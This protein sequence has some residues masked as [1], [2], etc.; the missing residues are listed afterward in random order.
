VTDARG[1]R[2]AVGS[3][4]PGL[5]VQAVA[6]LPAQIDRPMATK[7]ETT[8]MVTTLPVVQ[9]SNAMLQVAP[10][11]AP[12]PMSM[13]GPGGLGPAT[14]V[15]IEQVF[16]LLE[17]ASGC[18]AKNRYRVH[19]M[20]GTAVG[21]Q[22]MF[23]REESDCFERICCVSHVNEPAAGTLASHNLLALHRFLAHLHDSLW[24]NEGGPCFCMLCVGTFPLPHLACS[25]G[26][27]QNRKH[28][29]SSREVI[30]LQRML[31]LPSEL[32]R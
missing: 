28:H 16:D 21:P 26:C 30:R 1:A 14:G 8:P 22:T 24:R 3:V 19:P 17:V 4:A 25:R 11:T 2:L 20:N 9:A 5:G 32:Y 6:D 27:G 15:H 13:N 31:L 7:M 10:G 23:I 29:R 12:V 18:E